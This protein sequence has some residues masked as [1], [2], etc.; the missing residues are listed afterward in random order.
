MTSHLFFSLLYWSGTLP[1]APLQAFP[2]QQRDII[3]LGCPLG[4]CPRWTCLEHL[5]REVYRTQPGQV[6]KSPQL[7]PFYTKEQWLDFESL[8]YVQAEKNFSF[9]TPPMGPPPMGGVAGVKYS[10][11]WIRWQGKVK[12]TG[13]LSPSYF[14]WDICQTYVSP[15]KSTIY[16]M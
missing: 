1:P 11:M 14:N 15:K 13:H 2:S 3:F 12:V 6:P 8:S 4:S 5:S 10:T 16:C 7:A 9:C